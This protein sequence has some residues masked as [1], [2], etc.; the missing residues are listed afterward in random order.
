MHAILH[1]QQGNKKMITFAGVGNISGSGMFGGVGK[2][3]QCYLHLTLG[4]I[5][6]HYSG[7]K[8]LGAK[9]I[10]SFFSYFFKVSWLF[11]LFIL[12]SQFITSVFLVNCDILLINF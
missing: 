4:G 7:E 2:K 5:K 10:M 11:E 3:G 6:K 1:I 12:V 9:Q 8:G